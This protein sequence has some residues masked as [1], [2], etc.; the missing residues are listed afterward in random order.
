MD[1]KRPVVQH[2]AFEITCLRSGAVAA[3]G[4]NPG[5]FVAVGVEV[6]VE[7]VADVWICEGWVVSI[8]SE[9]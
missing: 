9:T 4:I 6:H 2:V 7:V 3:V 5:F 8:G 1:R